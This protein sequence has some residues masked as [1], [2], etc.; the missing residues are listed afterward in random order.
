M[1]A[2]REMTFNILG[3]DCPI[4]VLDPFAGTGRIHELAMPSLITT[5][6][7]EI[8]PEWAAMHPNTR[9]GNALELTQMFSEPFDAII[10][11]PTYGN[12]LADHHQADDPSIRRSY[13]HDLGH[14]LHPDNS[15]QLHFSKDYM[16]FHVKAWDQVYQVL[17]PNGWFILNVSDFIRKGKIIPVVQWHLD[18]LCYRFKV[19]EHRYVGTYRMKFGQN[20]Q[21][22]VSHESVILMKKDK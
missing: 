11:S 22:R 6:G 2:F 18:T 19:L 20:A 10:T 13:K 1:E 9:L 15:G 17:K 21:A 12:R 16:A 5:T 7:V 4:S 14:D 8:E 3:E